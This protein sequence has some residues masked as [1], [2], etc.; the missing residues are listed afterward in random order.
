MHV[1]YLSFL[2]LSF[3]RVIS[4][5][6]GKSVTFEDL[7]AFFEEKFEEKFEARFDSSYARKRVM[8]D[9]VKPKGPVTRS[10]WFKTLKVEINTNLI[11]CLPAPRLSELLLPSHKHYCIVKRGEEPSAEKNIKGTRELFG[12]IVKTWNIPNRKQDISSNNVA[13]LGMHKPDH[14]MRALGRSGEQSVVVVNKIMGM[15]NNRNPIGEFSDEQCGQE[16]DFLQATLI[17]QPWRQLIYGCLTDTRRFEFYKAEREPT[18]GI[19]FSRSGIIPDQDGWIA[20]Q[21]LLC[22]SDSVLGF[23]DVSLPDWELGSWLGSG[24][25]SAVFSATNH[26]NGDV[27]VCKMYLSSTEGLAQRTREFLALTKLSDQPNVPKEVVGAPHLTRSGL[28]VLLKI[29]VGLLIPAQVRLPV[30]AYAPLVSTLQTAHSRNLFH[31]DIAPS[32]VFGE[33]STPQSGYTVLLNDWGSAASAQEIEQMSTMATRKLFYDIT[34]NSSF[35]AAADL[36]ALVRTI[37]HLTQA[38]FRPEDATVASELDTIMRKQLPV[39]RTALDLA[40]A[41]DYDGLRAL[42]ME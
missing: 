7:S 25:T 23:E 21:K 4:S 8:E 12:D 30:S 3:R 27:C 17:L 41:A 40:A 33:T 10:E 22:Q 38:T 19:M 5:D 24:A 29:P 16:L 11:S 34:A 14:L 20:L 13:T 2:L 26:A 32:S 15:L 39:W 28:S 18:G 6:R 36:S 9:N 1:L 35:G 37:F 31:N 42:L